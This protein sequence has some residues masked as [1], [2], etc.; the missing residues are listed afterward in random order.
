MDLNFS[1][2]TPHTANMPS[3]SC[4]WLTCNKL[5]L[6]YYS[7]STSC[8]MSPLNLHRK[9][10][11]SCVHWN[12][13][14]HEK[15]TLSMK[16]LTLIVKSPSFKSVSISDTILTHSASGIM[17]SYCPAMSMSWIISNRKCIISLLM[18][19]VYMYINELRSERLKQHLCFTVDLKYS[20]CCIKWTKF[21]DY[22]LLHFLLKINGDCSPQESKK[23]SIVLFWE[24]NIGNNGR[25]GD[26]KNPVF[27]FLIAHPFF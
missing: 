15:D 16:V 20:C 4:R 11:H 1:S 14:N 5:L 7:F 8:I 24:E 22:S 21:L 25:R 13:C 18:T 23:S 3:N 6:Y 12:T 17:G 2:G 10:V 19:K 26:G 9:K 27:H